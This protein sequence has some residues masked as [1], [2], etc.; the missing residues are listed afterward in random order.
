MKM[1]LVGFGV[2]RWLPQWVGRLVEVVQNGCRLVSPRL[3]MT[4]TKQRL[5]KGVFRERQFK[6]RRS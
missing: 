1:S 6:I 3:E 5:V 4:E 2:L